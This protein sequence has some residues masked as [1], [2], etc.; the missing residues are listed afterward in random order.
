[1]QE[2]RKSHI[3]MVIGAIF[4]IAL[5]ILFAGLGK[6]QKAQAAAGV[7]TTTAIAINYNDNVSTIVLTFDE[8]VKTTTAATNNFDLSKVHLRNTVGGSDLISL[9]GDTIT[10]TASSTTVTVTLTEAQRVLLIQSSGVASGDGGKIVVVMDA[11]A[12]YSGAKD[13]A[14]VS[15]EPIA[16]SKITETADTNKPTISSATLNYN[17]NNKTLVVAFSETVKSTSLNLAKF[18]ANNATGSNSPLTD[19]TGATVTAATSTSLTITL[20]EAQRASLVAVS[21]TAGGDSSA[22][23]LDVDASGIKDMGKVL[24]DADA[25]N[26]VTETADT[27]APTISSIT[28]L[29]GSTASV[30]VA[31]SETMQIS[32]VTYTAVPSTGVTWSP[33][34]NGAHTSVTYAS[35]GYS[36]S[37][38][39]FT[40]TAAPDL[41]GVALSGSNTSA[42]ITDF[43]GGGSGSNPSTLISAPAQPSIIIN[44]GGKNTLSQEVTLSLNANNSPLQVMLSEKS[45][46]QGAA[47]VT[48]KPVMK[49]TLS[50]GSGSKTIYAKYQNLFGVSTT[51]SAIINF[52]ASSG[53]E[54]TTQDSETPAGETPTTS[55]ITSESGQDAHTDGALILGTDGVTVYLVKDKML[56]AFRDGG[57]FLSHG[58]NFSDVISANAEDL[59]LPLGGI[60]KAA[61]GALLK[62]DSSPTVWLVIDQSLLQPFP[63]M[64]VFSGRG[65]KLSNIKKVQTLDGYE[66][67]AALALE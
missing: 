45:D 66:T 12:A 13:I 17:D 58:Y 49:W 48:F 55:L 5:F 15:G 65:Y 18:H 23:V 8:A 3:F 1:M 47:W 43:G 44:S 41:A 25:N 60:M 4:C 14:N 59:S 22:V 11:G 57:E 61:S 28:S 24:N 20:T 35:S 6:L 51:T 54:D 38:E 56:Y 53:S 30:T 50:A 37:G 40:I 39:T 19:L 9:A 10:E 27:N 62:L 34:W 52:G 31:F 42:T 46:M 26:T 2:I 67:G 63:S 64:R 21:G 7:A 36:S 29:S 16:A 33:T 32:A